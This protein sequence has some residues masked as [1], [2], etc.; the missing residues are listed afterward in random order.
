MINISNGKLISKIAEQQFS[1]DKLL[2]ADNIIAEKMG[3]EMIEEITN[4]KSKKRLVKIVLQPMENRFE[5]I[6]PVEKMIY[7]DFISQ[8]G[9]NEIYFEESDQ[10]LTKEQIEE[11]LK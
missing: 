1:S 5:K 7:N 11:K 6:S 10:R 9:G 4:N 8:I 3:K 2:I